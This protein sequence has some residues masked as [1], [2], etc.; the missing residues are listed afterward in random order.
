[1]NSDEKIEHVKN[2]IL[3]EL[4]I[5]PACHFYINCNDEPKNISKDDKVKI[6]KK[7]YQQDFIDVLEFEYDEDRAYIYRFPEEFKRRNKTEAILPS[8]KKVELDIIKDENGI[9]YLFLDSKKIELGPIKNVPFKLLNLLF[10]FGSIKAINVV[11]NVTNTDR[12]KYKTEQLSLLKKQE[13]LRNRIK[14]LQ[15]ILK[16]K[17]VKVKLVFNENDETTFLKRS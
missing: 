6:L 16:T 15:R 11:F 14:E 13:I 1:M 3:E 9:G 4:K 2:I 7:L 5:N 10:P 8:S 12:S 17:K